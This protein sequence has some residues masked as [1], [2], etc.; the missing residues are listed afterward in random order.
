M[1]PTCFNFKVRGK[2]LFHELVKWFRFVAYTTVYWF[3]EKPFTSVKMW[4]GRVPIWATGGLWKTV[5]S[6]ELRWPEV[7]SSGDRRFISSVAGGLLLRWLEVY[8]MVWVVD[9][10]YMDNQ[11]IQILYIVSVYTP[12]MR[13]DWFWDKNWQAKAQAALLSKQMIPTRTYFNF[14]VKGQR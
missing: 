11:Q 1:I 4:P 10:P 12:Y 2:D 8:L 9:C 7:Y 5:S 14:K 13:L 6:Q 3:W